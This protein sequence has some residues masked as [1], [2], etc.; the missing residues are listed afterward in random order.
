MNKSVTVLNLRSLI[1]HN[2]K[3][4]WLLKNSCLMLI[5]NN[6]SDDGFKI[7]GDALKTNT[8]LK[9]LHLEGLDT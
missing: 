5:E 1:K 6:F 2:K 7:L 9:T 3:G 8:L 4:K